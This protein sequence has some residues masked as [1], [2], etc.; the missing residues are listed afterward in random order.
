MKKKLTILA[1]VAVLA[2]VALAAGY[3]TL[4]YTE[5]GGAKMIVASGGEIE[6][7][8]GGTLDINGTCTIATITGDG[9]GTLTGMLRSVEVVTANDTLTTAADPAGKVFYVWNDT[10]GIV[11]TLPSMGADE[12]GWIYTFIDANEVAASDVTIEPADSDTVNGTADGFSSDGADEL[13]C[14]VTLIYIH[15]KTDWAVLRLDELADGTA[16]WDCDS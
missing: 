9:T 3:S 7:A 5:P 8:S 12:D 13:P 4:I 1:I 14:S 2:S 16:A 11:L 15:D 6:V 10:D